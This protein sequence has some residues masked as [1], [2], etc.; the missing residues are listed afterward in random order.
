MKFQVIPLIY[1]A[2]E[3]FKN[4]IRFAV[5]FQDNVLPEALA[6][7]VGQVQKRYP[8]YSVKIEKE[9]EGFVLAEN[10]QPFVIA[11]GEKPVCLNSTSSVTVQ[12]TM[13]LS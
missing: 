4:T 5:E 3:Q 11:A 12:S 10:N 8:Y 13:S 9:G 1:A 7:A 6:D 2:N